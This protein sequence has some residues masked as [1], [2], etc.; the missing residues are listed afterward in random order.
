MSYR[1]KRFI[2]ETLNERRFADA[3]VADDDDSHL[4]L[5]SQLHVGHTDDDDDDNVVSKSVSR[6]NVQ[7]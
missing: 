6:L 1:L 3:A 7:N 5:A 2:D 4:R